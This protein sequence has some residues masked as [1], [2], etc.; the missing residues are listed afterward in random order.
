MTLGGKQIVVTGAASGIGASVAALLTASGADVIGVDRNPPQLEMAGF[1]QADLS[2]AGSID[3]LIA[4]LP[5]NIDGLCNIAG[6]P[7]TASAPLV[8]SV[9]LFGLKRLTLGLASKLATGASIVNLASLA[10]NGW[11]QSIDAIKAGLNFDLAAQDPAAFCAAWDIA[12]P[13][14]YFYSKEAVIA[15]TLMS[16]W[17]WR[18]RGIRM[19]C[20]SPGPVETPILQDFI[21]TL[22]ARAEEDMRLMDRAGRAEDV[23]PAVAFLLS[24]VSAWIRG[25]NLPCD[26]GMFAHIQCAQSGLE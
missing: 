5:G 10:G 3:A 21:A 17:R 15:W 19:N 6:L 1:F 2:D 4:A 22:G 23:A 8:L 7:P 16:R 14:S 9:N 12:G 20:V 24:D 25:V 11:A 26:G 18:D 13:R